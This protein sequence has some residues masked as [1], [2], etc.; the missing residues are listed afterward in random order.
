[1]VTH[2]D[3]LIRYKAE[4]GNDPK[5]C[6]KKYSEW[7]ENEYLSILNLYDDRIVMDKSLKDLDIFEVRK[8]IY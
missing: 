3:L 4:T 1:M 7:L 8:I 2:N 6:P 5:N